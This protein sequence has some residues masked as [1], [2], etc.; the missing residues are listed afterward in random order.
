MAKCLYCGKQAGFFKKQHVECF[1]KFNNALHKILDAI[2]YAIKNDENFTELE[3]VLDDISK[4]G[5]ITSVQLEN[6]LLNGWELTIDDF[7]SDDILDEQEESNLLK[8]KKHFYL[9]DS[10]L[11]KNGYLTKVV[12]AG[13]IRDILNGKIPERIRLELPVSLNFQKNEKVIWAFADTEY[14][15]DKTKRQYVGGSRGVSLRIMKGVYYRVGAFKGQFITNDERISYGNGVLIITN[16]NIYF[17]NDKKSFRV[18]YSKIV[19][20]EPYSN[21]ISFM[22]DLQNAK[23]QMF[24]NNNGWFTYNILSNISKIE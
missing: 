9:S 19:S 14:L 5:F 22:R 3:V 11:D 24:I 18:P 8:F 1:H 23:P 20:F 21:G 6:L 17:H 7:L 12:Q 16:K 2:V 10:E 13:V 4:D 15:E